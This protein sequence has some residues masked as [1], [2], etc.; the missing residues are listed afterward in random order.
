MIPHS[1]FLIYFWI[2]TVATFLT[3]VYHPRFS[4]HEDEGL[5]GFLWGNF[6]VASVFGWIFW[7]LLIIKIKDPESLQWFDFAGLTKDQIHNKI[8]ISTSIAILLSGALLF[9]VTNYLVAK[10]V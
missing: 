1:W 5:M 8:I 9:L 7:P 3:L 10:A 6:M 2:F 4:R